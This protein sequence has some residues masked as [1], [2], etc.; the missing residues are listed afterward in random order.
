VGADDDEMKAG[1]AVG[2]NAFP[3]GGNSGLACFEKEGWAE[4]MG[5]KKE[6]LYPAQDSGYNPLPY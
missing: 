3:S 5:Q 2:D 4:G 6:G 1:D